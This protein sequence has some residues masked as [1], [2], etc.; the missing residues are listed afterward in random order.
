MPSCGFAKELA[1]FEPNFVSPT[2]DFAGLRAAFKKILNDDFQS[3]NRDEIIEYCRENF[4]IAK[5]VDQ[6]TQ[7]YKD[8]IKN[9]K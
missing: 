9:D 8:L 1:N 3:K 5:V 4:G 7:T 2:E 6:L